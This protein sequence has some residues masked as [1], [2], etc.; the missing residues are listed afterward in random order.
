MKRII[1]MWYNIS[2]YQILITLYEK[3]RKTWDENTILSYNR[4][5]RG[6]VT[7]VD[8]MSTYLYKEIKYEKIS[9]Y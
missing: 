4:I 2:S 5:A 7:K 6:K 1:I 9:F 8:R 3:I